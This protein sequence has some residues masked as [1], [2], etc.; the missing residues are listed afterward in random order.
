MIRSQ[1][2]AETRFKYP[3][4]SKTKFKVNIVYSNRANPFVSI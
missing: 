4:P 2:T 3:T 1:C